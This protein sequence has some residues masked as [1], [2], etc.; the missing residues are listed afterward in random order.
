[1]AQ[2]DTRTTSGSDQRDARRVEAGFGHFDLATEIARLADEPAGHD[3]DRQTITLARAGLLR[4]VLTR[5][6]AGVELGG[7]DTEGA[8]ALVVL[9]GTVTVRRDGETAIAERDQLVVID[10]GRP[11]RA[12]PDTD[13]SL[14][15]VLAWPDDREPSFAC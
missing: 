7:D 9:E 15:L 13:A 11:W 10:R 8:I 1:M 2:P 4:V 12:V 6:A 3:Q 5:A 14:L